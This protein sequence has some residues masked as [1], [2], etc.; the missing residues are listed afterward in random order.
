MT[1]PSLQRTNRVDWAV[2]KAELGDDVGVVL[3]ESLIAVFYHTIEQC[4]CDH[5]Y[6]FRKE[7]SRTV[8]QEYESTTLDA[9]V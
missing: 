1:F 7:S 4:L 5:R 3:L 6:G 8:Q 9:C 2:R